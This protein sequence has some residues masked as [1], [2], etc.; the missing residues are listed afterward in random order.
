MVDAS[1]ASGDILQREAVRCH[2]HQHPAGPPLHRSPLKGAA[3]LNGSSVD[4]P[5]AG[6]SEAALGGTGGGGR[7]CRAARRWLLFIQL[8][9]HHCPATGILPLVQRL[10]DDLD[11]LAHFQLVERD[12]RRRCVGH[13]V[14]LTVNGDGPGD[15]IDVRD[16][17]LHACAL[18]TPAARATAAPKANPSVLGMVHPFRSRHVNAS[19]ERRSRDVSAQRPP[20]PA[21][22]AVG[23][24]A[25]GE[26]LLRR[27]FSGRGDRCP[28]SIHCS[29]SG[30]SGPR[31]EQACTAP[32]CPPRDPRIRRRA[33]R[34][35]G[36]R[37]RGAR[38]SR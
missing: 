21:W 38:A 26:R 19:A 30:P 7:P 27:P 31:R 34:R 8:L 29:P 23:R 11:L 25:A 15:R 32:R 6:R 9:D 33:A 16:R 1:S 12:A 28:R 20:T 5:A 37:C 17:P 4:S 36:N 24:A 18:A 13:A 10:E 2:A 35:D 22:Q 14:R 3:Q